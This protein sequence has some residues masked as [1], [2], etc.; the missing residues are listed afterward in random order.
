M[1]V[2]FTKA[3]F[4]DNYDLNHWPVWHARYS[5]IDNAIKMGNP[6]LNQIIKHAPY[7]GGRKKVLIDVRFQY[8]EPGHQS[9][10]VGWHVDT[11]NDPDAIHHIYVLGETRTQFEGPD[12]HI[13]TL[14][15]NCYATYSSSDWHRGRVIEVEEF[16][17]FVRIQETN[18]VSL[19]LPRSI[20]TYYPTRYLPDGSV[21]FEDEDVFFQRLAEK[22]D[23]L[24]RGKQ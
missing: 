11:P 8:M 9:S 5:I 22:A 24:N 17:L 1:A 12:G 14:P 20:H 16:R 2:K 4:T 15:Q 3:P 6:V 13:K 19:E 21:E 23:L 18:Q 7:V 10:F